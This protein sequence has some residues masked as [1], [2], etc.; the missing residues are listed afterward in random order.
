MCAIVDANAAHLVF[1]SRP[2]AAG[3]ELRRQLDRGRSRLVSG[4][5]NLKELRGAGRGFREWADQAQQSGVLEIVNL[6]AVA[7]KTDDLR[8]SR[9]L[10]SDD[11][12]VIAVAQLSRARLLF[13]MD[14]ELISD[15]TTK[16]F[17]DRPRGKVVPNPE[18]GEVSQAQRR[19][20]HQ[21]DL[22]RR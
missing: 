7:E 13:S 5:K 20:L 10:T 15:F 12:H 4:G 21:K 14:Q 2:S 11:P 16:L 9:A 22:C 6:R 17:V 3:Q 1:G 18:S 8:A 19:L